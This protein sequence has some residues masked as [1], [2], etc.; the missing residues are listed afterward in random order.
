MEETVGHLHLGHVMS[1]DLEI[2]AERLPAGASI[3]VHVT[4]SSV[5]LGLYGKW[6]SMSS[7]PPRN[8]KVRNLDK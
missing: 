3:Q 8:G 6:S 2:L 5:D 1:G 7:W 4:T